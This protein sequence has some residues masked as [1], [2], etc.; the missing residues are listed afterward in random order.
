MLVAVLDDVDHL[1]AVR[2]NARVFT[3]QLRITQNA[4]ERRAQLVA[5]GADVP[6]LGLV[7]LVS[8]LTSPLGH[9]PC[10]LQ[11]LIGQAVGL[12]LALQQM[13]LAVGFFLRKLAAFVRQHQP[14]GH[15]AASDQQR[16]VSL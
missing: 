13:C 2:R 3:H 1:L 16:R 9:L 4:V 7:G 11:G 5:D 15:N 8:S 6:A 14:P 10:V 12:N